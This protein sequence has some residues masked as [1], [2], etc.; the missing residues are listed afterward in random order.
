MLYLKTRDTLGYIH[1]EDTCF[2]LML[3]CS[4]YTVFTM[5]DITRKRRCT[6]GAPRTGRIIAG[7]DNAEISNRAP[8]PGMIDRLLNISSTD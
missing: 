8:H 2:W 5:C 6:F 3:I 7:L 4:L 1:E